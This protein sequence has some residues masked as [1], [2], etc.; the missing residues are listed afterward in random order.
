MALALRN[1]DR[2]QRRVLR[3]HVGNPH[4][5]DDGARQ[6]RTVLDDTGARATAEEMITR[7]RQKALSAL[8]TG[9]LPTHIAHAL[10]SMAFSATARTT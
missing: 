1:A 4:L 3:D 6:V 10:R 2:T 8:D 5:T 7:R 9:A